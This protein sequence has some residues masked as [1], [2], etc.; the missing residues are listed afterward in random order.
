MHPRADTSNLCAGEIHKSETRQSVL[1]EVIVSTEGPALGKADNLSQI[2]EEDEEEERREKREGEQQEANEE[3]EEMV[4]E[5]SD[6]KGEGRGEPCRSEHSDAK[7]SSKEGAMES[8][9]L[10]RTAM[11]TSE[12]VLKKQKKASS[13]EKDSSQNHAL[14]VEQD[15]HLGRVRESVKTDPSESSASR[16]RRQTDS[17][18]EDTL[19]ALSINCAQQK[20]VLQV[21][22]KGSDQRNLWTNSH[23]TR[24]RHEKSKEHHI[25]GELKIS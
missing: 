23:A 19:P 17:E 13:N 11:A 14:N 3:N 9:V 22:D 10:Q 8:S 25:K 18:D 15:G 16:A 5:V 12:R 24:L 6:T 4:E 21:I 7:E 1:M 2:R 20:S